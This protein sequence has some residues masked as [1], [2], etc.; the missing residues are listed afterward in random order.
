MNYSKNELIGLF[1]TGGIWVLLIT[2]SVKLIRFILYF[3]LASI[4]KVSYVNTLTSTLILQLIIT[5]IFGVIVYRFVKIGKF[6]KVFELRVDKKTATRLI[7]TTAGIVLMNFVLMSL[8]NL[9]KFETS[10][11]PSP[12]DFS[13]GKTI[14][15][16]STIGFVNTLLQYAILMFGF[17]KMAVGDS[18][19]EAEIE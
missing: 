19:E 1:L 9:Y 11:M 6:P 4:V 16:I 2:E 14:A 12:H 10:Q 8:N 17:Y 5:V 18:D 15:V 13:I 3:L 7:L